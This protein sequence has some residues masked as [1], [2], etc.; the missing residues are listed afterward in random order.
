M[1]GRSKRFSK[2]CIL[3]EKSKKPTKGAWL[4][5]TFQEIEYM[6]GHWYCG[7]CLR[8]GHASGACKKRNKTP[9]S[10]LEIQPEKTTQKSMLNK[11][12]NSYVK[13]ENL[14]EV[15][16]GGD[17]S[18]MKS[19]LEKD[20][21][22][23]KQ[24]ADVSHLSKLVSSTTNQLT[25]SFATLGEILEDLTPDNS[26]LPPSSV[27]KR[28]L[29]KSHLSPKA[30]PKPGLH[31]TFLEKQNTTPPPKT[32]NKKSKTQENSRKSPPKN[33]RKK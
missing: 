26:T 2:L 3:V 30:G 14:E 18:Q 22:R 28:G 17:G 1:E 20:K 24:A 10:E 15:N 27:T 25:N 11:N 19:Q 29:E 31:E 32:Q 12:Q 9:R 13:R 4:G 5:K 7:E 21:G 16:Q 8:F 33:N 6:E 23:E